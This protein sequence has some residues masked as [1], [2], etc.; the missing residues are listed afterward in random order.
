MPGSRC[1]AIGDIHGCSRALSTVIQAID[2]GKPD[3]LVFLGDYVNRGPDSQGVLEILLGLQRRCRC[4]PLLGNHEEI[5]LMVA[6]REAPYRSLL[7][8]GLGWEQT[9]QSYGLSSGSVALP[10]E[11][12]A[13][14]RSCRALGYE[15]VAH[16][17]S[18]GY[19]DPDIELAR[20]SGRCRWTSLPVAPR[21]H[22][23]GKTVICGHTPQESG[24]PLDLGF[25]KAIDTIAAGWLTA[26]EIE[27]GHAV[28]ANERGESRTLS[29]NAV[30]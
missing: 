20:Q 26:I 1:W 21:R 22:C 23:S 9:R 6:D 15:T 4:T 16:I 7:A 2:P 13:F 11:H 19:P 24:I 12:L 5:V 28:Q 18:H 25:L 29:P 3:H 10:A 8:A 17:F 27:T 14:L 30:G